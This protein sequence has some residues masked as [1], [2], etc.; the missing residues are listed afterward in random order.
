MTENTTCECGTVNEA[1]AATGATSECGCGSGCCGSSD[2]K[3]PEQE[4][5][6]LKAMRETIDARLTELEG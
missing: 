2:T 6:E 5:A 1:T 4:V 3:A